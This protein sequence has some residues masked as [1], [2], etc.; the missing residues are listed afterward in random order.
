MS[1]YNKKGAAPAFDV[2]IY[3]VLGLVFLA[4]VI[5]IYVSLQGSVL[6]KET[7][8]QTGC[9]LTNTIKCNGG[10]FSGMPSLC[11]PETLEEPI[12]TAKLA[13]LTR[14]TWWMYKEGECDMGS[15]ADEVYPVYTF[16]PEK[17]INLGE[18]F[19]YDLSHNSNN[20]SKIVTIENSDYAY[21]ETNTIGQTF[22]F[23]THDA[24]IKNLKLGE[25]ELYYILY[26][27]DQELFGDSLG[28]RILISSDPDYDKEWARNVI[29]GATVGTVAAAGLAAVTIFSGGTSL[30]LSAGFVP[31][32]SLVTNAVLYLV[33]AETGS[34]LAIA[35]LGAA[36]GAYGGSEGAFYVSSAFQGDGSCLAYGPGEVLNE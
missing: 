4:M 25:G 6:N 30:T 1:W 2:I 11:L 15:A 33:A 21:L 28:D 23:D 14:D 10:L 31:T 9:W 8:S 34:T 20:P 19:L 12:D 29:V 24:D 26:Y 3:A 27:D 35:G 17:D 13:D 5:A 32:V 22:C 7:F 36:A 18:F 16:I